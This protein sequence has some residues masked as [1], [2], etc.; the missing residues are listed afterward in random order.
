[1]AQ[2]EQSSSLREVATTIATSTNPGTAAN[3]VA[4]VV[5]LCCVLH[6]TLSIPFTPPCSEKG[7]KELAEI[8]NQNKEILSDSKSFQEELARL[9]IAE[10]ELKDKQN[11]AVGISWKNLTSRISIEKYIWTTGRMHRR[12]VETAKERLKVSISSSSSTEVMLKA[13]VRIVGS[14]PGSDCDQEEPASIDSQGTRWRTGNW[15]LCMNG[16]CWGL[17]VS[18]T[19]D[20]V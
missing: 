20:E 13:G 14:H 2:N 9:E 3:T 7:L 18:C 19:V 10:L 8:Y 16:E 4:L 11:Q 1:M 15:H 12:D 5:V 17:S 6:D